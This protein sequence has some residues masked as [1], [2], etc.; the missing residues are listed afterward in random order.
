MKY[1]YIVK[2]IDLKIIIIKNNFLKKKIYV[3]GICIDWL[4]KI[5]Y[6]YKILIC[7][8]YRKYNF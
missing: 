5:W 4:D 7:L 6:I 3:Y 2:R 8:E 1:M